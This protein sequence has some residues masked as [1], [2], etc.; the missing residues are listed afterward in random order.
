MPGSSYKIENTKLARNELQDLKDFT[1]VIKKGQ[2]PNAIPTRQLTDLN[3]TPQQNTP[4]KTQTTTDAQPH[5]V[6]FY[7][8]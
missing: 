5:L 3:P 8:S 2:P 1:E 7:L 4:P 6:H